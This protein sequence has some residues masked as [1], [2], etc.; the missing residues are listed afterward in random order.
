MQ[1]K[2][3]LFIF[4]S[5]LIISPKINSQKEFGRWFFRPD[6]II[7]FSTAAPTLTKSNERFEF[8]P[9]SVTCVVCDI[10]GE[11]LFFS[12]GVYF[13]DRNYRRMQNSLNVLN[14]DAMSFQGCNIIIPSDGTNIY[15]VLSMN[16]QTSLKGELLIQSVDMSLNNGYGDI[17][18]DKTKILGTDYAGQLLSMKHPCEGVWSIMHERNNNIFV[19]HHFVEGQIKKSVISQIGTIVSQQILGNNIMGKIKFIN[20]KRI[21]L[22]DRNGLFEIYDFNIF[23][24][25]ISNPITVFTSN[26][27]NSFLFNGAFFDGAFSPSGQ[28]LYRRNGNANEI[29]LE[30]YDIS[31]S[32]VDDIRN[33]KVEF[34]FPYPSTYSGI[35]GGNSL[36]TF[37]N[38][39]DGR[40]YFST[41]GIRDYMPIINNP[42][43]KGI[44]CN[45]D[46]YGII[47]SVKILSNCI[48]E[49]PVFATPTIK[50]FLPPDTTYCKVPTVT[51][52]SSV[53]Q[54]DSLRWSD[55]S[56]APSVSLNTPGMYR[57]TLYKNGCE[58][59]DTMTISEV[60]TRILDLGPDLTLCQLENR[61]ITVPTQ[62]GDKLL[63]HDGS[64]ANQRTLNTTGQY[65][66]T[67]TSTDGCTISDT[68][69]IIRSYQK[70]PQSKTISLCD[71]ETYTYKG[72]YYSAG[73]TISDSIPAQTGCDTLL[74]LRLDRRATPAIFRDTMT[75]TNA[76]I[77]IQN[78]TY[79]PGDTI[80]RFKPAITGCDTVVR[81]V[82]RTH[83]AAPLT[84]SVTDSV[85]CTGATTGAIASISQNLMWSTGAISASV[86]LG[87]GTYTVTHTDAQ[88]C[89]QERSIS[90]KSAPP[91]T[92]T[93]EI[94]DPT[95]ENRNGSIR[96]INQNAAH[97]YTVSIDGNPLS[98]MMLDKLSPGKYQIS[99]RDRHGCITRDSASL[100]SK[101]TL[102]VEMPASVTIEKGKT[103]CITYRTSGGEVDT[104]IF[105][106]QADILTR[107][108][109]ICIT[110]MEDR[111]YTITFTDEAGC[112]V[113]KVLKV[114]VTIPSSSI[115]LPNIV[116]LQSTNEENRVFYLKTE[117]IT[118]DMLIYDRWG[119]VQHKAK[120]QVGG[121]KSNAWH[122]GESKV[123]P[124]VYVY[125]V[126]IYT[127]EG[128]VSRY[129]TV[130]V[131]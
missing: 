38:G 54:Y 33:S 12:D 110:G 6:I 15:Y 45:F 91:L 119:N 83:Q 28:F 27:T 94:K 39:I 25:V 7:D 58:Y 36:N 14:T 86:T 124:G 53:N 51:I 89:R 16:H 97:P 98:S 81:T 48:P 29:W 117:G 99:L 10:K 69:N 31:L 41:P 4:F 47:F 13:W 105:L 109:T 18:A 5:L 46:P 20:D 103:T 71:G 126:T 65:I 107:S 100:V 76:P 24:G 115:I 88:G 113:A 40:I 121:D 8:F 34:R 123:V 70:V 85:V 43:E 1:F 95:C 44:G 9:Y 66:A 50:N 23:T 72:V 62:S 67:I 37:G 52:S 78:Q 22:L 116:S 92:Y 106:P 82:Y 128:V 60:P 59:H 2:N 111:T 87:A 63:W 55:G 96:L 122:P 90:I 93:K 42:D 108:D 118:Y 114:D 21:A 104:I 77:T 19:S 112:T 3:T 64:N 127:D 79:M 129:G 26:N 120:N 35:G 17:D 125:I 11:L 61:I 56:T 75:C 102:E 73:Q 30:Q 130:T 101:Q 68:I 49:K 131:L 57:L 74:S 80:I 84:V 32:S